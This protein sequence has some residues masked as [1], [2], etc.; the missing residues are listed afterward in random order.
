M[1]AEITSP[2]RGVMRCLSV[3]CAI[4]AFVMDQPVADAKPT[5]V[6]SRTSILRA[7]QQRLLK[8]APKAGGKNPKQGQ[9]RDSA[10]SAQASSQV[11]LAASK[12]QL[13]AAEAK[14]RDAAQELRKIEGELERSQ[15]EDSPLARA[16]ARVKAAELVDKTLAAGGEHSQAHKEYQDVRTRLLQE[17]SDWKAAAEELKT[18]RKEQFAAGMEVQKARAAKNLVEEQIKR[19]QRAAQLAEMRR[20]EAQMQKQLYAQIQKAR[21]AQAQRGHRGHPRGR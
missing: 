17:D 4:A 6:G 11:A 21:Q 20:R 18:L 9:Q 13:S 16:K 5:A 19:A 1:C 15:P 14:L 7:T 2:S 3:C 8:A 12:D 10:A